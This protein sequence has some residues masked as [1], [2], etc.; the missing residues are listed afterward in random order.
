MMWLLTAW[1]GVKKLFGLAR[2]Y[3]MQ[4]AIIAL[5]CLSAWLY[6]GKADALATVAKRDA[7]IAAMTKASKDARAAQIAMNKANTEKQTD[8][9][10]KADDDQTMRRDIADRS[11]AYADGMRAGAYCRKA[12][13]TSEDRVA[14]ADTSAGPDAVV[15]TRDDFDTLIGNTARLLEVKAWGDDLVKAGLAV[16]IDQ[17]SAD[18]P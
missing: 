3:P 8:I 13:A 14:E 1:G 10:R 11:S 9:A 17:I 16:P 6:M 4:A 18:T 15:L 5:L 7:T 12:S 2:R